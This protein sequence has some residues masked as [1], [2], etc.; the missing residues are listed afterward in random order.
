MSRIVA[1]MFRA[2][3]AGNGARH[4]EG[5]E[6]RWWTGAAGRPSVR[7]LNAV[8]EPSCL[9]PILL[10]DPAPDPRARRDEEPGQRTTEKTSL[11][12][13]RDLPKLF[14]STLTM[15]EERESGQDD[16]PLVHPRAYSFRAERKL[17][18]MYMARSG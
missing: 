9:N 1:S 13:P 11:I 10:R 15:K 4:E 3:N 16:E 8:D 14:C 6:R 18:G 2:R 5:Q 17:F 12:P 7:Y